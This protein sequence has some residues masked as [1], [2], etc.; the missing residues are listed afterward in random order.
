MI[1]MNSHPPSIKAVV[2]YYNFTAEYQEFLFIYLR[3]TR[4]KLPDFSIYDSMF[5]QRFIDDDYI[6]YCQQAAGI[7]TTGTIVKYTIP[8]SRFD[9]KYIHPRLG[10]YIYIN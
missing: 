10:I 1:F 7:N 5:T 8:V 3:T 4:I 9:S 2:L 6:C